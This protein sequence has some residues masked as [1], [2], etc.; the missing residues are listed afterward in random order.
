[1]SPNSSKVEKTFKSKETEEFLDI[2]FYRPFGYRIAML[3]DKIALTPN[4]VTILSILLGIVAGHLFYYD[5]LTVNIAGI[6]ILIL[7]EALD[8]ADGQLARLTNNFSRFGRILDGFGS[9]LSF[10]SI[11]IH[12]CLRMM[13]KGYPWTIFLIAVAAG[14][15]HSCQSAIGDYGRNFYTYFIY[16]RGKSELDDSSSLRAEYPRLS[17]GKDFSKK[18]LMRLY[19]NYTIQ[20]EA[21]AGSLFKLYRYCFEEF[22]SS[23]PAPISELYKAEFGEMIKYYNILTTN[24]RMIALFIALLTQQLWFYYAFELVALNSLLLYVLAA[25]SKKASRVFTFAAS[26]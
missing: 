22:K 8:S 15:S 16:G 24:T 10:I 12:L 13:N 1:M 17:W 25:H 4:T 21:M 2:V 7:S 20:Q 11:Y 23:I 6:L 18:L 3:A 14:A 5:N 19:I 9:N 26:M